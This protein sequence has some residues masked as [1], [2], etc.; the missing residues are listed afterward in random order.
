MA[1]TKGVLLVF[2]TKPLQDYTEYLSKSGS[3]PLLKQNAHVLLGEE[4]ACHFTGTPVVVR[5]LTLQQALLEAQSLKHSAIAKVIQRRN[6]PRY[7]E[8]SFVTSVAFPLD[9]LNIQLSLRPCH[10]QRTL[11]PWESGCHKKFARKAM[12]LKRSS[13]SSN[14]CKVS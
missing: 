14:P 4:L 10:L 1:E 9:T 13:S 8:V 6:N 12:T 2:K 5:T 7:T 11:P 3:S